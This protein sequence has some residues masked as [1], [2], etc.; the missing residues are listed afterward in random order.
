MKSVGVVICFLSLFE[1]KNKKSF[2]V[3]YICCTFAIV[4]MPIAEECIKNVGFSKGM[5]TM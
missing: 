3:I 1:K 5:G 4:L 2:E